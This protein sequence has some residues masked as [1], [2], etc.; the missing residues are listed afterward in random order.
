MSRSDYD[1]RAKRNRERY[2]S[3]YRALEEIREIFGADC[4][5]ICG[6]SSEGRVGSE[7]VPGW[8]EKQRKEIESRQQAGSTSDRNSREEGKR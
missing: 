3:I 1:E 6:V 5:L 7:L 8:L 2:P 4:K